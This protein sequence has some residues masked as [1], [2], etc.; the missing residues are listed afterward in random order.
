MGGFFF[1]G[2]SFFGGCWSGLVWFVLFCFEVE[3][4]VFFVWERTL[5]FFT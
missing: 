5:V 1:L 4:M 2:F 3:R